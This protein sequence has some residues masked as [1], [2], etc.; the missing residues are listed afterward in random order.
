MRQVFLRT[1]PFLSLLCAGIQWS[2]TL[3]EQGKGVVKSTV[4]ERMTEGVVSMSVVC[5]L[6]WPW[7]VVGNRPR[8]AMYAGVA[9]LVAHTAVA[10]TRAYR[11]DKLVPQRRGSWIASGF[12]VLMS[13]P[14]LL[15]I[16]HVLLARRLRTNIYYSSRFPWRAMGRS[17]RAARAC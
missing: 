8:F 11:A 10:A 3:I 13:L 15:G 1:V 12:L 2:G 17:V 14:C 4:L 9:I 16:G 7:A 5:L 6:I